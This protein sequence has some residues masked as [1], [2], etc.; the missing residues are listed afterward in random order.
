MSTEPGP[1]V[2]STERMEGLRKYDAV[3]KESNHRFKK[4]SFCFL[5]TEEQLS[6]GWDGREREREFS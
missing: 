5:I 3:L 1:C 4:F 2:G 6:P